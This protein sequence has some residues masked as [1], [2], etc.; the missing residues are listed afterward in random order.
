[1]REGDFRGVTKIAKRNRHSHVATLVAAGLVAFASAPP[2]VTDGEAIH[3]AER[4]FQR[5]RQIFAAELRLGLGTLTTIASTAPFIGL[6]GTV[7]WTPWSV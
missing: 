7:F 3:T 1:L 2:H 6:L 5:R 4:A